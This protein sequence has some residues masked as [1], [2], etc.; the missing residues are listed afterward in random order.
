MLDILEGA[1]LANPE[2][3][4]RFAGVVV[5]SVRFA[6]A[7]WRNGLRP[8]DVIVAVERDRVA[9]VDDLQHA[10]SKVDWGFV[11]EIVREGRRLRIVVP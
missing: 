3:G 4:A 11:L 6:S 5:V 2:A 1:E 9:T 7:M 10:L 8:D